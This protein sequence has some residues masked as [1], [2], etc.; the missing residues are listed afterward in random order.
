MSDSS[1]NSPKS[2][3]HET[4]WKSRARATSRKINFGWW[5]QSFN[6]PLAL[7]AI[8]IAT[9]ILVARYYQ[10][11]PR[12][13]L[14]IT[15][16]IALLALTAF[17]SWLLVRKKF[18]SPDESLVRLE[19]S[20]KMKNALSAAKA[21][22]LPWPAEPPANPDTE[23]KKKLTWNLPRTLLPTLLS[24]LLIGASFIIPIG[25]HAQ[26]IA[27][28]PTPDSLSAIESKLELLKDDEIV[29]EDYIEEMEEKVEELKQQDPADWFSHSSLE[30]IDNLTENHNAAAKDLAANLS[31]AERALQNLQKHG[32]KLSETAKENL[33]NEFGKA[34]ENLDTG[35]MKPNKELLDQLKKI[36]PKQL[37]QLTPEQLNQ[38]RE[39]MRKMANKLKQQQ[40][41]TDQGEGEGEGDGED[42]GE[43][44][45]EGEN[46]G[47]DGMGKGGIQ[48]GP[49]HAPGVLGDE[50]EKLK[51]GKAEKIDP[52]SLKESLP[53]D[54]L[55]TTDGEHE[56]DQTNAKIRSGGNTDN[57][58]DGG[59]RVWKNSLMPEEKKALKKFF[60]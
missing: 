17:L 40:G 15:S 32:D 20:L 31:D 33:L 19:D 50:A 44:E 24:L 30:A 2:N 18:E 57:T 8:L 4:T 37:N 23:P 7:S 34:V 36:D 21:G 41:E 59:E 58:G 53:G 56:I 12:N 45:G 14:L 46:E 9:A 10:T 28:R 29:Q 11:L 22:I 25:S 49:G 6:L 1:Q 42:N 26:H 47:E 38:L 3:Q 39:N 13:S 5:L 52:K 43:G 51:L 55:E 27:S 54:L 35:N 16:I 48:R 60:K